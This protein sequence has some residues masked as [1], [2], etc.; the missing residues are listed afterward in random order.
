MTG[1]VQRAIRARITPPATLRTPSR[2]VPFTVAAFTEEHIVLLLGKGEW[3]TTVS[4]DCLEGIPAFLRERGVTEIDGRYTTHGDPNTFDG[5]LKR[6]RSGAVVS[7]WV[8]SVLNASGV[9]EIDRRPP[10]KVSLATRS[11]NS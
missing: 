3:K 9:V 4:W 8:A 1:P 10:A 5:Y 11:R 7:G 6:N 2:G